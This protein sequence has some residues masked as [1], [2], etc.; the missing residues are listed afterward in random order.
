MS[1]AN[2]IKQLFFLLIFVIFISGCQAGGTV[3]KLRKLDEK[4]G[5]GLEKIQQDQQEKAINFLDEK[6]EEPLSAKNLSKEQKEKIEE[7]LSE[8]TLNRYGDA[9]DASYIGG[10]PLY[11]EI[12]REN[13]D[14]YEYILKNH[15][16]LSDELK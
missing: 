7:W 9:A 5:E 13:I 1:K 15:P 2:K 8:K 6:K 4:V 3:Q 12:T 10:T 11:D 14:R 16:E